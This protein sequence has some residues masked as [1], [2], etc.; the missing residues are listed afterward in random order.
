MRGKQAREYTPNAAADASGS[1]CARRDRQENPLTTDQHRG[2]NVWQR[3]GLREQVTTRSPSR[4]THCYDCRARRARF[5]PCGAC[6][7]CCERLCRDR[8]R[9]AGR[10]QSERPVAR[11][12][13]LC[14]PRLRVKENRP[15]S[16]RCGYRRLRHA[17]SDRRGR[18]STSWRS[19]SGIEDGAFQTSLQPS[20]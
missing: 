10:C 16:G 9:F 14:P 3:N 5:C 18:C 2:G 7:R 8:T 11:L 13:Y 6:R 17:R 1:H 12:K 4:R 15:M 20:P 19:A